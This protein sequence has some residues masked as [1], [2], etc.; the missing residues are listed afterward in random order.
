MG[1]TTERST[2]LSKGSSC[3]GN[4]KFTLCGGAES[5]ASLHTQSRESNGAA[6]KSHRHTKAETRYTIRCG[7]GANAGY[8]AY[9]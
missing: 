5:A 4:E 2:M 1:L 3:T 7:I 6:T 8:P 9:T